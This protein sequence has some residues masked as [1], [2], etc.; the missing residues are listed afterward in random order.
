MSF[1]SPGYIGI[2]ATTPSYPLHITVYGGNYAWPTSG[3]YFTK[4]QTFTSAGVS[5]S[6]SLNNSILS[7]GGITSNTGFYATSDERIKNIIHES[8]EIDLID[9]IKPIQF[10]YKDIFQYGPQE[11]MGFIAQNIRE[12]IPSAVSIRTDII[13]DIFQ[14]CK[15]SKGPDTCMS[16]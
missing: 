3:Y 8:I 12:H 5:G 13:P 1:I 6:F 2:G 16:I 4:D 7:A 11:K 9:K 14:I 15:T 10:T